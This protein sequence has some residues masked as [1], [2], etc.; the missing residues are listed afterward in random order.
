M[1]GVVE[2]GSEPETLAVLRAELLGQPE[3][4][5]DE[6]TEQREVTE[7]AARV[8]GKT[9]GCGLPNDRSEQ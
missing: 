7:V 3:R 6:G 8:V 9:A 1:V 5:V 4:V 2:G